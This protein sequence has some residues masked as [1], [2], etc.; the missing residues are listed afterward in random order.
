LPKT[1]P[2]RLDT[3]KIDE[4]QAQITL[5]IS[6]AQTAA[7]CPGC[8]ISARRIHSHYTRTLADLP[9]G[10][11]GITWQLRVRKFFC[12]RPT[13]PR[14]IFTERLPGVVVPWARRTLRLMAHLLA[15]GLAL[16]GAAGVRLSRSLGLTVSRN[17]LLRAIRRAPYPMISPPR[18]LSVDDFALRKRHTY[19]TILVDLA[20]RRPLALLPDREAAT[21]A[22]WL[23]AYPE[24]EVIVR[25][26]A[27][28]YA[29]AA[30][31]GAP[32]AC[33][34]ADR[35][36]LLQNLADILT[37]VFM[38]HAPQLARINPPRMAAPTPVH[39]PTCPVVAPQPASVPLAPPQSSTAAARLARQRRTQ[40]WAYY[41]QVWTHHRQGWTLDAIAAQVGLSRRTVQRYLQSPT[42]PERQ[43]RHGRD[44]SILDP[45]KA[46]LLAGWNSGCRNGRHLFRMIRNQGFQGQYGIV[47]LYV[48]R[49]RQAQGLA[50]RQRRSDQPLP[51]VTE[52]PRRRLTPRQATW[53][54]LRPAAR[55]T[56][57]DHDQRAQLTQQ[58]PELAEAVALAQ[59]FASLVRQR[60][61]AQLKPWL[62]RAATSPLP[63]FRRFAKGLRA[64]EA[65]VHAAVTLPWSQ[66]P[67]E[68][69][70][71]R[72][73][74]LKRQMFGRA[75][76]DLLARRF[77]LTA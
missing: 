9:W 74:M 64:D 29:E 2:L 12:R 10:G 11:Y 58:A 4:A 59:D 6:S 18:V 15:I 51:V 56:A 72:L 71:N 35:F 3:W 69:Q 62:A 76:L 22:E 27:E 66:G 7:R 50:P 47:A 65:A 1:T 20:Q 40:R 67:I 46:A 13:C 33:Q 60:Q 37:Q 28:A 41:Q 24:V 14:R 23:Q 68:G 48:R 32:A 44:H 77:L 75:R 31:L 30:R 42:F 17:T 16:G 52:A 25:D 21:V 19:G 49:M 39:D 45:Y 63:P 57:Q 55:L 54:V 38:A 70:I 26:R 61:P 8:N 43:P 36:H 5:L 53:L 34:V 73:K